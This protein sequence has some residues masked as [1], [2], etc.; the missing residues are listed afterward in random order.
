MRQYGQQCQ[1]FLLFVYSPSF[2]SH[3]HSSALSLSFISSF[4]SWS[5]FFSLADLVEAANLAADLAK[6]ADLA[7][8]I[9]VLHSSLFTL[10]L[11][12]S[13]PQAAWSRSHLKSPQAAKTDLA[14]SC[15]KSIS[16]LRSPAWSRSRRLSCGFVWFGMGFEVCECGGLWVSCG[17]GIVVVMAIWWL[18][19]WLLGS[20]GG[21]F[22]GYF[23]FLKVL[24][25]D[26]GLCRWWM[27]VLLRQWLLVAVVAVMVEE[28]NILF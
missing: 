11:F 9:I 20:G 3:I 17:S 7:G 26:V 21:Y 13:H 5:E 16:L 28:F 4:L 24:L 19:W 14:W 22:L 15:L 10:I 12:L 2:L 1:K 18:W 6:V 27:S 23:L 25:V 8:A